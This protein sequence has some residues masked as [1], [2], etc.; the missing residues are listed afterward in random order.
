MEAPRILPYRTPFDYTELKHYVDIF[1]Q[2]YQFLSITSLGES[3]L[4]NGIPVLLLGH[5]KKHIFY[6][7]AHHGMEWITS[8]LLMRF[9][10]DF[11]ETLA[12]GKSVYRI[13]P[14]AFCMQYTIHVIPML[15]P[16]GVGYQ[17]H[18]VNPENP[19]RDRV[20]AMNGG[21]TDFTHWQANARGVDLNHNY[22]AGF[23]EYKQLE[24]Q[25]G[26]SG[27]APTR[28]SGETP[29]SEP[30][31]ASLCNYI[32]FHE[33]RKLILTLHTQ[34]EEIFYQSGGITPTGASVVAHRISRLSGYR[35]S[36][37]SGL[38]SYGGL[39]DWCVRTLDIPSLTLECGRG[40]NPLPLSD[41]FPIYASLREA[42]FTAPLSL[43]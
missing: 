31:V 34:G 25:N 37:A 24:I 26:I 9:V 33:Q 43:S 42:L 8:V 4:G 13:P 36:E 28:F 6:V 32:R 39:T 17:I 23:Q 1:S 14:E 38:S 41:Y 22:D 7:G 35:L 11:C 18:G 5:G 21:N 15:N 30:E 20:L 2:R 10:N 12:A 27:G 16:D 29:E 3:I 40:V 19:I